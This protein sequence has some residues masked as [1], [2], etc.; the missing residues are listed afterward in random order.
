VNES[1]GGV[2]WI[3]GEC[4][5]RFLL[6]E[7]FGPVNRWENWKTWERRGEKLDYQVLGDEVINLSG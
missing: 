2:Y 6:C 5:I 4:G 3:P 7:V 1:P